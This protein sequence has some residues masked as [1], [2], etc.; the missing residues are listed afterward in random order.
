MIRYRVLGLA[1]AL[2]VG[3]VPFEARAEGA[4]RE[5]ESHAAGVRL[6]EAQAIDLALRAHPDI[7]AAEATRDAAKAGATG[8]QLA[9][10][11]DLKIT[12][13][14][15]RFSSIPARYRSFGET[16]F[17]QLLDSVG[18][19]AQVVLPLT[20]AFL[21]LAAAARAAGREAEAASIE[22]VTVRSQ[23]AYDARLAFFEYWNRKIAFMNAAELLNSAEIN[24]KDQRA[25]VA[26][27][28]VARNELLPF[29]TAVDQAAMTLETTR[30][31]LAVAEAQLR[32]LVPQLNG[33]A[34]EVPDLPFERADQAP[35]SV[36]P[37]PELPPRIASLDAQVRAAEARAD[38]ASV[39][40]LPRLSA[41]VG[42]ELTA[43][44]PRVFVMS[45]LVAVPTWE[46]GLQLE[47]SLSQLTEG[48]ATAAKARHEHAALEAKL[49]DARRRL[50][51]E[52]EGAKGLLST[53]DAR[54][55]RAHDRVDHAL[56][57]AKA[58]RGE[59]EAGTAL[60]LDV[61]LAETDLARAKNEHADAYVARA[62]ALAR[63]DFID[64]R[65]R[66]S[67][68]SL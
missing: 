34:I 51:G 5:E 29:E 23:V 6:D 19:R 64:G 18:G 41:Y 66:P 48:S 60:S 49:A 26:A 67:G 31:E 39:S 44:T 17:P 55:R 21:G 33:R 2:G 61:V 36:P 42:G 14:Y 38:G 37:K 40:R 35:P 20:D 62:I 22:V 32:T 68:G 13:H 15:T 47:W 52:R 9:R 54:L 1:I 10:L 24:A 57:L 43:P 12:A 3:L 59:L 4:S 7:R 58:R 56:A 11:P 16:V 25:R 65:V 53:A 8:A 27:G 50:D 46:A 45:S 30:G 28:S 63:L